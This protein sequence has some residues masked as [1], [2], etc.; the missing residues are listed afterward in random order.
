ML[1]RGMIESSWAFPNS[2]QKFSSMAVRLSTP[3]PDQA[4]T[5]GDAWQV[6]ADVAE[7]S[8]RYLG[9]LRERRVAPTAEALATLNAL[10]VPLQD[11]PTSP[12]VAEPTRVHLAPDVGRRDAGLEGSATDAVGEAHSRPSRA[13]AWTVRTLI[14]SRSAVSCGV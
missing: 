7:R 5:G 6:L 10:D 14:R 8:Q 4:R 1:M 12:G 9:S 3:A 11:S 13:I 2:T